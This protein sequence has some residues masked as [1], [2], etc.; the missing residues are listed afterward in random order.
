MVPQQ[1]LLK[2]HPMS[3]RLFRIRVAKNLFPV[4]THIPLTFVTFSY[5]NN[6]VKL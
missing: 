2:Q 5:T 1:G 3:S 4:M 6:P